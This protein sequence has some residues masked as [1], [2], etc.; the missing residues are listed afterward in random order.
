M[1]A[2]LLVTRVCVS[3]DINC[4]FTLPMK[5]NPPCTS[6]QSLC[7]LCRE[8]KE[9][10]HEQQ[11]QLHFKW[12]RQTNAEHGTPRNCSFI[13]IRVLP[14]RTLQKMF[15]CPFFFCRKYP[16]CVSFCGVKDR[17]QLPRRAAEKQR[18]VW[19]WAYAQHQ[20]ERSPSSW[21]KL[22]VYHQETGRVRP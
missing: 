11:N 8:I 2:P 16:A 17:Q 3:V 20:H 6:F 1:L 10:L 7:F 21:V 4:I 12:I 13:R 18:K 22:D 19:R 9:E 15:C 5:P 14:V